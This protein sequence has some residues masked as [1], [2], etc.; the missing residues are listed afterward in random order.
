MI[1]LLKVGAQAP[2]FVGRDAEGGEVR[3]TALRGKKIALYFY[4][5][6]NTSGC[7]AEA[8]SLRDHYEALLARNYVIL[9]ISTDSEA[10]HQRFI[11]KYKLPFTLLADED[12]EIHKQYGTWVSKS[13]YGRQYMG[14]QRVTFLIDEQG[15]IQ[16]IISKVKTKDHAQQIL[17]A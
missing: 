10:S 15:I 11:E 13:M 2:E 1:M 5:K 8:C 3:L 14:T 4:P 17:D 6:D 16:S 7:T 9:G 12:K